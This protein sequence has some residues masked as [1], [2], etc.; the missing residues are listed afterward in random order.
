MRNDGPVRG[1]IEAGGLADTGDV[2]AT[3]VA[4][5]HLPKVTRWGVLALTLGAVGAAYVIA[6]SVDQKD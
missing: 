2:V 6:P 5:R 3:L 4:F 1:W